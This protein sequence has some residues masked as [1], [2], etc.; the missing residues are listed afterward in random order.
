L[1]AVR[2]GLLYYR[3]PLR[4]HV[5]VFDEVLGVKYAGKVT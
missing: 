3:S 1:P 4:Q 5:W 2:S